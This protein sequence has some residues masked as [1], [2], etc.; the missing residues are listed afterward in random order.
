MVGHY[1]LGCIGRWLALGYF[2]QSSLHLTGI[3]GN[4]ESSNSFAANIICK[5][6]RDLFDHVVLLLMVFFFCARAL[7]KFLNS[8]DLITVKCVFVSIWPPAMRAHVVRRA[9][10][11]LGKRSS[12]IK[13]QQNTCV[14]TTHALM[15]T[16]I[17]V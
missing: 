15:H 14:R 6:I 10:K 9:E 13:Q 7:L 16:Y 8:A 17:S 3:N 12:Q 1:G 2:Q 11:Q 4:V 5:T